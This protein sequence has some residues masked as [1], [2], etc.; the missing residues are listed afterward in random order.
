MPSSKLPLALV[1]SYIVYVG[2]IGEWDLDILF[3]F[4]FILLLLKREPSQIKLFDLNLLENK[5]RLNLSF[6]DI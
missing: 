6:Q 2:Y 5:L 3:Y 4:I 1:I